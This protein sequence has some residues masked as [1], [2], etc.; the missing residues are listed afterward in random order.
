MGNFL[1]NG[2]T[3][4]KL[5]VRVLVNLRRTDNIMARIKRTSND[6][7]KLHRKLKIEQHESHQNKGVNSRVPEETY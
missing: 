5:I 6:L 4:L 1:N 3:I 7:Q 2:P